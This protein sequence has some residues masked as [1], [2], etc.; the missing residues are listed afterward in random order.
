MVT[1]YLGYF[2]KKICPQKLSKIA[3]SNHTG[4]N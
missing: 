3:Q 4:F 1:K 2:D